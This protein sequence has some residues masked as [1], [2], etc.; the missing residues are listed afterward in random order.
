MTL[1]EALALEAKKPVKQ[2]HGDPEHRLQC[3]CFAWFNLKYRQLKGILYAV[4]NGGSRNK[5]E[6]A[7]MKDEGVTAGVSDLI[8]QKSNRFYGCLA[9]EMKT[10]VG[11]QSESQKAWQRLMEA[12]GNKYVICRSLDDFRREVEQYMEDI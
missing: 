1:D 5:I 9:I 7:R 8:L 12:N 4:P 11:R 2:R 6:A 10:K 3:L